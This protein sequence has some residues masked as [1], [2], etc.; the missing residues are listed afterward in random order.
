MTVSVRG[1]VPVCVVLGQWFEQETER[2][3]VLR[4]ARFRSDRQ[5]GQQGRRDCRLDHE[6]E[7]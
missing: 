6:D 2:L 3:H 4:T 1:I 7:G 5:V